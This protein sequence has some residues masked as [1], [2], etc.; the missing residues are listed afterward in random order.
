MLLMVLDVKLRGCVP[1]PKILLFYVT[2][3]QPPSLY[4]QQW[5]EKVR[6][7]PLWDCDDATAIGR[8]W[9][10]SDSSSGVLRPVLGSPVPER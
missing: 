8:W 6:S 9:L 2:A 1:R 10:F 4:V 3:G 7:F 5:I